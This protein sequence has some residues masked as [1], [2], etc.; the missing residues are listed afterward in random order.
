[1]NLNVFV[2]VKYLESEKRNLERQLSSSR[3]G[4]R[5]KSYE[6]PEKAYVELIGSS[7]S[8]DALE[9]ENRELR[10]KV[11]KLES[12]LAEKE[13][14]ILQ[15]KKSQNAS[16]SALQLVRADKAG[17]LERLRAAQL[18][19]DKLLESREMSHRHQIMRLESQVNTK[20]QSNK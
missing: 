1:M 8:I 19:A 10:L 17:E 7:I 14:E 4:Y 11:R 5:S 16:Q 13:S 18:Q 20:N 2:K 6:R 9:H 15:L 12:S 3:S